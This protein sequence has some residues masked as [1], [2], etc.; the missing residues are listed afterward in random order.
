LQHLVK[1]GEYDVKKMLKALD[2]VYRPPD[3]EQHVLME[4]KRAKRKE[5]QSMYQHYQ[6]LDSLYTL[7]CP[8]DSKEKRKCEVRNC[9]LKNMSDSDR[10]LITAHIHER[11]GKKIAQVFDRII[12]QQKMDGRT[13]KG[14][15]EEAMA[16]K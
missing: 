8:E 11:D 16:V 9:M 14:R 4:F 12:T 15:T 6:D 5:D 2:K 1:K 7:T 3:Y 10:D 13:M